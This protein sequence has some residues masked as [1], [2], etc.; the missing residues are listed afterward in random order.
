MFDWED[1]LK[2]AEDLH[3][4]GEDPP[5]EAHERTAISRAY[6]AAFHKALMHAPPRIQ[7][8]R[9]EKHRKVIEHYEAGHSSKEREIGRLLGALRD[10]RNKA[11]YEED[12]GGLSQ[13]VF[14]ADNSIHLSKEIRSKLSDIYAE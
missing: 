14:K 10:N 2:L 12:I 1:Y 5:Q 4:E 7:D 13:C 9:K 11:D 6:Y 8:T 3:E